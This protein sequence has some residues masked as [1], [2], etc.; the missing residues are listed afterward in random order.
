MPKKPNKVV[1]LVVPLVLF[2][3]AILVAVAVFRNSGLTQRQSVQSAQ[4]QQQPD[5]ATSAT[6]QPTG[7]QSASTQ[8]TPVQADAVQPEQAAASPGAAT[9]AGGS[10]SPA[11]AANTPAAEPAAPTAPPTEVIGVRARRF[12]SDPLSTSFTPLGSTD[13]KSPFQFRIDFSPLGAGLKNVELT[14]HFSTIKRQ[15][16]IR[17]QHEHTLPLYS[18]RGAALSDSN[19]KPLTANLV[20]FSAAWIEVNGQIVPLSTAEGDP[21]W[22]QISADTPGAFEAIIEDATGREILRVERAFTLSNESYVVTLTQRVRNTSPSP[23]RFKFH[24]FGPVDLDQDAF[25][26]G[27]DK[28]R[29]RFGYLLNAQSDPTR[30]F[31]SADRF[32]QTRQDVLGKV[33]PSFAPDG[34]PNTFDDGFQ[35]FIYPEVKP[36]WPNEKSA[37]DQLEFVWT[38]VSNRYFGAAIHSLVDPASLTKSKA[39]PFIESVDRLVLSRVDK[40]GK[41]PSFVG[42]RLSTPLL[43][44]PAG[45]EANLDAGIFAGPLSRPGID[46][47]PLAKAAGLGELVVFNFGGLC[48]PCTFPVLTD[49]LF[50]LLH[51]LH[52]SVFFDW[53]IAIIFL[54][55]IVRSCLHPVTKW[56]QIRIQRFG[57]QMQEMAPKQKKIQEKYKDEPKVMQQE[58]AKLWREEGVNPAGMLGCIPM[59]LQMPIWIALYATLYFAVE[60]R[61]AGAFFGVFQ[62]IS[63]GKWGFLGDLSEADRLWEFGTS[64]SIPFLSTMIGPISSFNIL[65]II[66]GAVFF[67]HQKYLSPPTTATMTPEQELQ[68]KMVKW[69][70]VFL[71]PLFMYNAPSGLA[72]YFIANSTFAIVENKWIRRHIDK[73][74][75]LNIEKIK[76]KNK[77]GGFLGRLMQAAEQ[78]KQMMEQMKNKPKG[79][80]AAGAPRDPRNQPWRRK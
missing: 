46:A 38:G 43:E 29:V 5:S 13:P 4:S 12:T 66:L 26:Y 64:F 2:V 41:G 30:Q 45:G 71:F 60:L 48:G 1:R 37:K 3:G 20:P 33:I 40:D 15:D 63:S 22:R 16:R 19:G 24:Q 70:S 53:S 8:A 14:H 39:M 78:R 32:M 27:G 59:F 65:P 51:F 50:W 73:H 54:V 42:V 79:D 52:D 31:V 34:T 11:A 67:A 61:H 21:I 25:A 10:G 57:K 44:L 62:A 69:M 77:G 18:T 28:R 80:G 36:L 47:D 56:S 68:M 76:A 55:I 58:M 72:I 23:V 75:L 6:A 9:Q 17:V 49:L 35:A 7:T 74:D